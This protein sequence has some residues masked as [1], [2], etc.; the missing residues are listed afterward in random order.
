MERWK[1]DDRDRNTAEFKRFEQ[2]VTII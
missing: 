2:A 1:H